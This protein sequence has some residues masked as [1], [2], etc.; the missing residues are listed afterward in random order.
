MERLSSKLIK[1][2][3]WNGDG[4]DHIF[5]WCPACKCAHHYEVPR[6]GFNGNVD[7]PS[8]T[9]SMLI[10]IPAYDYG[11]GHSGPRKTL[12][13]YFIT[14]GQIQYCGDCPHELKGQTI[15]LP[16]FPSGCGLGGEIT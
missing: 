1:M 2:S 9:P 8:F 16:D 14:A 10:F 5:H 7:S 15:P 6:W 3:N 4:K 12:C 13:H 11:Q